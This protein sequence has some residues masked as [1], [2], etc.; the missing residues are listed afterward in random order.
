MKELKVLDSAGVSFKTG[1]R[2]LWTSK[3]KLAATVVRN[4][5]VKEITYRPLRVGKTSATV[6]VIKVETESGAAD[7]TQQTIPEKQRTL[8]FS[9]ITKL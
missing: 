2:V 3:V 9:N 4:A 6:V 7:M 1:D 8:K 5:T